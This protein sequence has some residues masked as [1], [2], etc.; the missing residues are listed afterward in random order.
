MLKKKAIR[1]GLLSGSEV[2]GAPVAKK[3]IL[4]F[5]SLRFG[6]GKT[7]A[8]A[9][10]MSLRDVEIN[11][12][13]LYDREYTDILADEL[14]VSS[15]GILNWRTLINA[16]TLVIANSQ[17]CAVIC[18][19]VYPG[20]HFYVTHGYAN[21][22][23]YAPLLRRLVW[24]A[25]VNLPFTKIIACGDSEYRMVTSRCL[26]KSK[27]FLIRNGLPKPMVESPLP[28]TSHVKRSVNDRHLL[29]LGRVSFQKGLDVLLRAFELESVEALGFKLSIVGNFQDQE[30][31][32]CDSVRALIKSSSCEINILPSQKIDNQFFKQYSAL[33]SPSRFEGLPYTIL[34]AALSGIPVVISDCPG[35]Y[36]VVPSDQYGYVFRTDDEIALGRCLKN[37]VDSHEDEVFN[38]VSAL[39]QKVINEFSLA[40]FRDEYLNLIRRS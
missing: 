17:L 18:A 9:L 31:V 19:F 24:I 8:E 34:E 29:Y 40:R 16:N 37:L 28:A 36:D 11:L 6:G 14:G 35:N 3:V 2:I 4:F 13:S 1:F 38:R 32:Y 7:Y 23:K 27:V 21:G 20:R 15:C 26:Q 10:C 12:C 30:T 5:S 39:R 25:Q 33:V 22:L